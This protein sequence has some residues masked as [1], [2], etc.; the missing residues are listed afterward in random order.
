MLGEEGP[1]PIVLLLHGSGEIESEKNPR[2]LW[3][4][5]I[6]NYRMPA[7]TLSEG[8]LVICEEFG[9]CTKE[10]LAVLYEQLCIFYNSLQDFIFS[11]LPLADFPR[12]GRIVTIS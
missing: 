11:Y 4:N 2:D 8:K 6:L 10:Y 1:R 5:L 7:V 3:F 12:C 9:V